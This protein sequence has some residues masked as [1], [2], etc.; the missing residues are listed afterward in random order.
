MP[1]LRVQHLAGSDDD[2]STLQHEL[3][4]E[5]N[6]STGGVEDDQTSANEDQSLSYDDMHYEDNFY[7]DIIGVESEQQNQLSVPE[8]SVLRVKEET[9]I[10]N[11]S[12]PEQGMIQQ[13]YDQ[14]IETDRHLVV[15]PLSACSYDDDF[16]NDIIRDSEDRQPSVKEEFVGVKQE[17]ILLEPHT[18]QQALQEYDNVIPAVAQ[19]LQEYDNAIP[20]VADQHLSGIVTSDASDERRNTNQC[21]KMGTR[22]NPHSEISGVAAAAAAQQSESESQEEGKTIQRHEHLGRVQADDDSS[23]F[24]AQ[25]VNGPHNN[26]QREDLTTAS[27]HHSNTSTNTIEASPRHEEQYKGGPLYKHSVGG[28]SSYYNEDRSN[29][30]TVPFQGFM[31][32]FSHLPTPFFTSNISP[33]RHASGFFT[34]TTSNQQTMVRYC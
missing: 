33:Y 29:G 10:A 14:E 9:L 12:P 22:N 21:V 18:A 4:I 34:S 31:P 16:Y 3:N 23:N 6:R 32:P 28:R 26:C 8:E 2:S 7:D 13:E 20:A 25:I 5:D 19:A 1:T 15:A 27:L 24:G 30:C 11:S 17:E